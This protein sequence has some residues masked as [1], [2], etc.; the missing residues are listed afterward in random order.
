[1][2]LSLKLAINFFTSEKIMN[3]AVA[4]HHFFITKKTAFHIHDTIYIGLHR[5][6]KSGAPSS[7]R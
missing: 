3:C 2:K 5:V 1:M 6:Q 4:Q 7:Y